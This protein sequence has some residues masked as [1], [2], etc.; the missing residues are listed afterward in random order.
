M[1]HSSYI[2]AA[3]DDFAQARANEWRALDEAVTLLEAARPTGS[4]SNE[5]IAAVSFLRRL[6]T[7]LIQD[8]GSEDNALPQALRASLIS[9]GLFALKQGELLRLGQ[10]DDFDTVIDVNKMIR[11]SLA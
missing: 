5:T 10:S 11:D 3:E 6:W 1:Y 2:A 7:L 4:A 8:L 9:I